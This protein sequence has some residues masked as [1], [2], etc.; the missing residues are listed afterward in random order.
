MKE[1][2]PGPRAAGRLRMHEGYRGGGMT[3]VTVR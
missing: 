3:A 1:S 2:L